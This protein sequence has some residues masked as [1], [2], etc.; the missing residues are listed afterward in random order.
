VAAPLAVLSG[1]TVP[2]GVGEQATLQVTPLLLGSPVTVAVNCVF[3]PANT[4]ADE[5]DTATFVPGTVMLAA[6]ETLLFATEVAVSVTERSPA[7]MLTGAV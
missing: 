7:G 4:V 3:A 5:G 1:E 2:Q 6:A